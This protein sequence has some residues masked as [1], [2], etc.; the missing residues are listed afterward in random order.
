MTAVTK[1]TQSNWGSLEEWLSLS[2][3][4]SDSPGYSLLS[5]QN[6]SWIF[7]G[8]TDAE[9]PIL[10][11]PDEKSQLGG[12][13]PDAGK[14]W[15]QEEKGTTEDEGWDG[16]MA[17]TAWW[18]WVWASFRSWRWTGKP[19]MLQSIGLQRVGHDW[20]NELN[21][22]LV[23]LVTAG[24]MNTHKHA[25]STFCLRLSVQPRAVTQ[26]QCNWHEHPSFS[27]SPERRH[28]ENRLPRGRL[29]LA[30]SLWSFE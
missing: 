1:V 12:K 3:P 23:S 6:Q 2:V 29:R 26:M 17:S 27:K 5:W 24:Q 25:E 9:A 8:R 22:P 15:G 16:W 18:T 20:A 13:D 21:W 7:I 14:D 19:G 28:P 11:T 10:C 4:E 30:M